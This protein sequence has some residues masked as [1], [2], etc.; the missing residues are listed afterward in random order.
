M[1]KMFPEKM[2]AK[3]AYR[4]KKFVSRFYI[5]DKNPKKRENNIVYKFKC[6]ECPSTYIG[7]TARRLEERVIDHNKRDKNSHI[8]KHSKELNHQ[9]IDINDV[10]KLSK[11]FRT[12]E[13][14][15]N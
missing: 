10:K 8:L 2:V 14:H 6:S 4:S 12:N 15:K 9:Q 5:K 7:E 13:K 3:L 1:P 11:N